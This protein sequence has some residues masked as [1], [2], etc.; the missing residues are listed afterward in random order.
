MLSL[1]ICWLCVL[2][3]KA[4]TSS[5]WT[6]D[7]YRTS[8]ALEPTRIYRTEF[9]SIKIIYIFFFGICP[10]KTIFFQR[11][12]SIKESWIIP[13]TLNKAKNADYTTTSSFILLLYGM[14]D[15]W[16]TKQNYVSW[17]HK[18][19]IILTGDILW[20]GD[21]NNHDDFIYLAKNTKN[22][23]KSPQPSI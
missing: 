11:N 9:F 5:H 12:P 21:S 1:D 3:S 13:R 16:V 22:N 17:R 14:D 7:I 23:L 6:Q 4:L 18:S 10:T 15:A 20:V 19:S 8:K 2:V